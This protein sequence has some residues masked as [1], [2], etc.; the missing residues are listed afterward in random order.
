MV[1]SPPSLQKS[2]LTAGTHWTKWGVPCKARVYMH[3]GHG[4]EQET[5]PASRVFIGLEEEPGV[6]DNAQFN[7]V[8]SH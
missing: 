1:V 3:R 4:P 5:S 8:Q 6:P 2:R 7:T